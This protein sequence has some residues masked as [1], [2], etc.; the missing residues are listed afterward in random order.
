MTA[1][2]AGADVVVDCAGFMSTS[3]MMGGEGVGEGEGGVGV[4]MVRRS[5]PSRM[6]LC[7]CV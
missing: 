2:A 7:V 3:G 5:G 4:G 6:A 1:F